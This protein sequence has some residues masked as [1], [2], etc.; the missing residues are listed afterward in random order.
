MEPF[1]KKISLVTLS[2]LSRRTPDFW[3]VSRNCRR[4][5]MFIVA[6]LPAI[7][8]FL[9]PLVSRVTA[10][11][12]RGLDC[13]HRHSPLCP[14]LPGGTVEPGNRQSCLPHQ[15]GHL[16]S[17]MNLM[18]DQSRERVAALPH[19]TIH[20]ITRLQ[21]RIRPLRLHC[22]KHRKPCLLISTSDVHHA[23]GNGIFV[24]GSCN[25]QAGL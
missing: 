25:L 14:L 18:E 6:R 17:M 8:M 20:R 1:S 13:R 7:P 9:L 12:L 4:S 3:P 15:Y 22:L 5:A 16:A 24:M 19:L 2:R 10:P 21:S 23:L 11:N